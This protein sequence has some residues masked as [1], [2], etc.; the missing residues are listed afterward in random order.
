MQSQIE[1]PIPSS[2]LVHANVSPV[3]YKLPKILLPEFSGDPLKWQGFWDQY[4]VAIDSKNNTSDIDKFNYLKGCL[5]GEALSAVSGL[6]LNSKNYKEATQLL[7]DRFGNEQILISAHMESLLKINKIKSRENIKGL[8]MLYNHVESCVRNL[9]SL[10]LDTT[11]YGSLLIPILKDRLPDD[12]T[13][14]IAR[15]F[16]GNT[17]TLDQ[18][19]KHFNDELR[20]QENCASMTSSKYSN[21]NNYKNQFTTS[22]LYTEARNACIYCNKDDHYASKCTTVSSP[23]SRKAILRRKGRCFIGLDSGHVAKDCTSTYVCRK[24]KKG[25]HHISICRSAPIN[26]PVDPPKEKK[27]EEKKDSGEGSKE[28]VGHASCNK[29]GI[30]LQTARVDVSAVDDNEQV[31][32]RVLF[33]S[34][35]QRSYISEK[36]RN[37][38]NLKAVRSEKVIIK[39]FGQGEESKVQKF[40]IVQFK[41][42]NKFNS[43][44]IVVEALCVP[45]ICSPLTNQC[46]ES[47]RKCQEFSEFEFADY[48][49]QSSA[50][51]PVGISVGIDYYHAFMTGRVVRSQLGPVASETKVGW[52][53]SGRDVSSAGSMHCLETDLLRTT[54][55]KEDY[56][57]RQELE[58]FWSVENIGFSRDCNVSQFEKDIVHNGIRYVAKLPFKPDHELLQD[59]FGVCEGRLKSLKNRLVAKGILNAYDKVFSDYEQQGIIERVP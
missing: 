51:R 37:R 13:M 10:K 16:G 9:R 58:K 32:T 47:V 52:V 4:Q 50:D 23:E 6:T 7:R 18:V 39:T 34:G 21:H 54:V 15:K 8:R 27:K 24:C 12:I 14:I 53:V 17:W 25:K 57:L 2:G 5:K 45:S 44:F 59:N 33:D 41:I 46:M 29:N 11:G 38:L 20:A 56:S 3:Q 48:E 40:D 42:K 19:M 49:D 30:L 36:V 43:N 31:C 35:S 26:P 1:S 28:F 22:G 55:E